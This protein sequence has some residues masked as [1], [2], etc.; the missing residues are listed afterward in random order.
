MDQILDD[1]LEDQML[2]PRMRPLA[3]TIAP[4]QTKETKPPKAPKPEKLKQQDKFLAGRLVGDMSAECVVSK[5]S[6][7]HP[8]T[9]AE[10]CK[11]VFKKNRGCKDGA[12]CSR[13]HLC[14]WTRQGPRKAKNAAST[15]PLEHSE[16]DDQE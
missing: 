1:M 8:F 10:P 6:V 4:K 12:V 9:C 3:A 15:P 13:C 7:G 16:Q 11:Y 5:G 14:K 2:T